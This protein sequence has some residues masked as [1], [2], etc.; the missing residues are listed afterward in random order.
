MLTNLLKHSAKIA[1]LGLGLLGA[2]TQAHSAALEFDLKGLGMDVPANYIG[3]D[4]LF[5]GSKWDYYTNP[6]NNWTFQDVKLSID[7]ITGTGVIAGSMTRNSDNSI[8][9]INTTLNDLVVRTGFGGSTVHQD[10]N[11]G[12]DNL[13]SILSTAVNGTG[14]EWKSLDMTISN[15]S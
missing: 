8:W 7:D 5:V 3:R 11:A 6:G 1:V 2:T 15:G 14:V 12:S 4:G 9:T 13:A 10:Y